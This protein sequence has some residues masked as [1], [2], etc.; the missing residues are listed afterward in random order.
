MENKETQ[1][2]ETL[3]KVELA[4]KSMKYGEIAVK[5]RNGKPIFVDKLER[6]RVG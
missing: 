3:R 5:V 2:G 4:F 1:I 6:E